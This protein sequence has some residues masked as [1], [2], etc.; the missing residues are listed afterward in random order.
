MKLIIRQELIGV[1]WRWAIVDR[2]GNTLARSRPDAVYKTQG[3]AKR[4]LLRFL[5][6]AAAAN[7]DHG[8][9]IAQAVQ[10]PLFHLDA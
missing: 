10:M 9:I 4:E 8:V 1:P 3:K 7:M 5:A 6:Q 2:H